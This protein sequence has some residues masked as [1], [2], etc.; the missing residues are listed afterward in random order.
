[1]AS[2]RINTKDLIDT[3]SNL[4]RIHGYYNTSVSTI[5]KQCGLSKASMYHHISSKDALLL[6]CVKIKYLYFKTHFFDPVY[7]ESIPKQ[8]RFKRLVLDIQHFYLQ[9]ENTSLMSSLALELKEPH[10]ELKQLIQSFFSQWIDTFTY[11][12]QEKYPENAA[13]KLAQNAVSLFQGAIVMAAAYKNDY[14]LEQVGD[15]ILAMW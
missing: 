7:Q 10:D 1:M 3:A 8:D 4:F 2:K 12:L 11:L 13:K 14:T 9:Q 5:A 15:R 6:S